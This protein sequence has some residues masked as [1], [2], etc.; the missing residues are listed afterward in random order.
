MTVDSRKGQMSDGSP[1]SPGEGLSEGECARHP[2]APPL[3][4][5]EGESETPLP[6]G[7][8]L[9]EGTRKP[10]LP[11]NILHLARQMRRRSTNAEARLWQLLRDR[12][13]GGFKFRRQHP[14]G[15]HI[16]DF[17]CHETKL[18]IELDGVG[19]TE[20]GQATYDVE[21]D[22][23]IQEAG[24]S[25]VR[26]W[27]NE[28]L[29]NLEGVAEHIWEA[30]VALTP[31]L[32]QG[33]RESGRSAGARSPAPGFAVRAAK[34]TDIPA[35]AALINEY[36][37]ENLL[38]PRTSEGLL[39]ALD[40]LWVAA[41]AGQVVGCCAL[42]AWNDELAEIRS[43]AVA[44]SHSGR[45]LGHALVEACVEEARCRGIGRVFA[46]TRI[47]EFFVRLG[48]ART[49]MSELPQKVWTDCVRCPLFE[50]CD[51][52]PMMLAM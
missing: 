18:G 26:I 31:P 11:L 20:Q 13:F 50:G 39:N 12:R 45:G 4:Q 7:E 30:L 35:A 32:S 8:G 9:G 48:F 34:P 27:N 1:L 23:V 6:R 52:V 38:L 41:D 14:F 5:G 29:E 16:I 47:P 24:I 2:P 15:R 28:V 44:R 17:Y 10:P 37:R 43:L 21:R 22:S 46:L 36:A 40:G 49:E 19:R 51:E 3:S 25:L 42:V 33:E